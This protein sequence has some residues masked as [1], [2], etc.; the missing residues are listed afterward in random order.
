M[1]VLVVNTVPYQKNG[2]T[3]VIW[4]YYNCLVDYGIEFD[5]AGINPLPVDFQAKVYIHEG[6]YFVLPE[7]NHNPLLYILRLS[8][9][10]RVNSYDI[11]HVHGNSSTMITEMIAAVLGKIKIRIVHGHTTKC[12]NMLLHRLIQP[13]F[14]CFITLGL[15]C[16][17]EAG[18][19]LY[20]NKKF[21]ICTNAFN[22]EDFKFS[23][24]LRNFYRNELNLNNKIVFGYTA[25]LTLSKNHFFLLDVFKKYTLYNSDSILLLIGKGPM[26]KEIEERIIELEL[27]SQVLLLGERNDVY[28]LLNAFDCVL[29]PSKHEGLGIALIEA[30]VNGI[31]ILASKDVIPSIVKLNENFHFVS[32][33][34]SSDWVERLI[35]LTFNREKEG[36]NNVIAAGYGI[37]QNTE[38][39][40]NHY[41]RLMAIYNPDQ[42]N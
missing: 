15:A 34:Q 16:S 11:I 21:E 12:N 10:C 5:F 2:I 19:F 25:T 39:I 33:E 30:Q 28:K 7:R 37:H 9:I 3:N 13:F 41:D 38:K 42:K 23:L 1:K 8:R 40:I 22:I 27:K 4:Q 31:P 32:L 20:G 17:A 6:K 29:F 14:L 24:S 18:R 36:A 35:T 26:K